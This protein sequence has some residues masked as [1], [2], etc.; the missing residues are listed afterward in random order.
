MAATTIAPRG[1]LASTCIEGVE[2]TDPHEDAIYSARQGG[3]E[4]YLVC[5]RADGV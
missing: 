3:E 5:V 2:L 4:G 1:Q